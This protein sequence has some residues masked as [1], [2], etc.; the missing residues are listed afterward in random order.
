MLAREAAPGLKLLQVEI[1][2]IGGLK[3]DR[4]VSTDDGAQ[5]LSV[6]RD[7]RSRESNRNHGCDQ[8]SRYTFHSPSPLPDAGIFGEPMPHRGQQLSYRQIFQRHLR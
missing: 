3:L 8:K 4:G 6:L 7:R 2:R 1:A 5:R